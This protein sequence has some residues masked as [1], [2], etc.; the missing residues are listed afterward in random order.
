MAGIILFPT[1]MDY[2]RSCVYHG[3]YDSCTNEDYIKGRYNKKY[4]P[5]RK[6]RKNWEEPQLKSKK[7]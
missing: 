4:C 3:P 7:E 6:E 5:F 2:C 1:H